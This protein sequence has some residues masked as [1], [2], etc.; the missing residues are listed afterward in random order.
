MKLMVDMYHV[1]YIGRGVTKMENNKLYGIS[2][3][4]GIS[5]IGLLICLAQVL[6][7]IWIYNITYTYNVMSILIV[8]LLATINFA[9]VIP[10]QRGLVSHG[11]VIISYII[12]T[13]ILTIAT[14]TGI[15]LL[16]HIYISG[17]EYKIKNPDIAVLFILASMIIAYAES[18]LIEKVCGEKYWRIGR[19]LS[20][21]I[22]SI[23]YTAAIAIIGPTLAFFGVKN[24]DPYLAFLAILTSFIPVKGKISSIL[25]IKKRRMFNESVRMK[26]TDWVSKLPVVKSIDNLDVRSIWKFYYVSMTTSVSRLAKNRELDLVDTITTPALDFIGTIG[27]IELTITYPE[28]HDITIAIPITNER[29]VS[30]TLSNKFIIFN[31]RAEDLSIKSTEELFV[32]ETSETPESIIIRRLAGKHVEILCLKKIDRKLRNLASGWFIMVIPI[33]S[34]DP[35]LAVRDAIESIKPYL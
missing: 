7:S 30:E 9:Y 17:F 33:K 22:V 18:T 32:S 2:A 23:V 15:Y 3:P 27:R 25:G 31:V 8:S 5:L 12:S 29:K 16:Y 13:A 24:L 28:K 26:I 21:D 20:E 14:G 35:N 19:L 10:I 4:M 34:E 6:S 11:A 1:G